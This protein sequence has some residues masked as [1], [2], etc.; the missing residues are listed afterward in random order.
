MAAPWGECWCGCWRW[1]WRVAAGQSHH[2]GT[3][4]L[5]VGSVIPSLPSLYLVPSTCQVSSSPRPLTPC[6]CTCSSLPLV[7]LVCLANLLGLLWPRN[8]LARVKN[9]V[10]DNSSAR[11]CGGAQQQQHEHPDLCMS[12]CVPQP[13]SSCSRRCHSVCIA[14]T[15]N[16]ACFTKLRRYPVCVS[17]DIYHIPCFRFH[18]CYSFSS[19]TSTSK[20]L[21]RPLQASRSNQRRPVCVS[22]NILACRTLLRLRSWVCWHHSGCGVPPQV[23]FSHFSF[24]LFCIRDL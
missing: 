12:P 24:G 19:R 11:V 13:S 23:Q 14:R 15:E 18:S 20:D 1:W 10:V 9:S 16:I 2:Y 7:L 3:S 6:C 4:W 5:P 21:Q 8:Q 17:Y 22:V